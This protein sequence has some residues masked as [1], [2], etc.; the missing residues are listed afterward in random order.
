M[1]CKCKC[2]D[3]SAK[4]DKHEKQHSQEHYI[5]I[6]LLVVTWVMIGGLYVVGF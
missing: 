6:A 2:G 5:V 4:L 3:V 1:I